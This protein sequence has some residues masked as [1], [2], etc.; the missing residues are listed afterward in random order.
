MADGDIDFNNKVHLVDEFAKRWWYVLP[1]WPPLDFDYK[2]AL[3]KGSYKMVEASELRVP[4]KGGIKR[5]VAIENYPGVY[6]DASG[7]LVDLRP[8]E[9][10][11]S[12]KNFQLRSKEELQRMLREAYTK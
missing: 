8:A 5:V 9:S 3:Q 11:P 1:A 4:E 6:K 12:L 2:K 10:M 7:Q